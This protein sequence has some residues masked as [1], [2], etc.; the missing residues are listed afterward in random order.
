[1]LRFADGRL[2]IFNWSSLAYDSGLRWWRSTRFF[3]ER[4]QAIGD[5][6][7]IVSKDGRDPEPIEVERRFHNVGGM[8]T[9]SEV[10]AHTNP[11]GRWLNP[12]RAYYMYDEMVETDS[13]LTDLGREVRVYETT[14]YGA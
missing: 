9:L 11:A 13:S 12:F 3:A 8:E 4:G 2:G 6:L 10:V 7:T 14:E 5:R 1:M